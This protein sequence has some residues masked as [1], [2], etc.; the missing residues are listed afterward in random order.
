MRHA[1]HAPSGMFLLQRDGTGNRVWARDGWRHRHWWKRRKGRCLDQIHAGVSIVEI[2][3]S[4]IRQNGQV[5]LYGGI[6][7]WKCVR[8]IIYLFCLFL[9]SFSVVNNKSLAPRRL[10]L[11]S[12]SFFP[13]S[14][15]WRI[16]RTT[17]FSLRVSGTCHRPEKNK[18]L[19]YFDWNQRGW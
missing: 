1:M 4:V 8:L 19:E 12:G 13:A 5:L 9:L 10:Y 7:R 18:L 6:P 15:L 2:L 16:Q 11:R 17:A 3:D 14:L